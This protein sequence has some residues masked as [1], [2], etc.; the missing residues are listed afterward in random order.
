MY[1]LIAL[2][3]DG[4]LLTDNKEITKENLDTIYQLIDK[5]YEVVI[6]TGRNY[7]SARTITNNIRKHLI[8][9]C[10]NGNIVRD[11]IDDRVLASSYLNPVDSKIILQEGHCTDE[12]Y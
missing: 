7:Y 1:K 11:T 12:K 3:L 5:G 2:D 4:T 6:A 9:I 8:Y 10:N